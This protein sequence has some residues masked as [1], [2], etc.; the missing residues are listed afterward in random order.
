LILH[1]IFDPLCGWCYGA[2]P[3]LHAAS[4]LNGVQICL[5]AGG[6]MMGSNRQPAAAIRK[7]VIAHDARMSQMSGQ[8]IGAQYR[9]VF[10]QD[11][12]AMFDSEPPT[13]AILAAEESGN[14]LRMLERIQQARFVEGRHIA[15]PAVLRE[16]AEELEIAGFESAYARWDG[17]KTLEHIEASRALLHQV[18]GQGFPTFVLETERGLRMIESASYLGR[19]EPWRAMLK[20]LLA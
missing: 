11:P 10:L 19:V 14:G 1:Y 12:E 7:F 13:V 16:L 9:D 4:E 6:M 18:G 2:A 8:P 15:R 5:H 17:A 3:L 20:T